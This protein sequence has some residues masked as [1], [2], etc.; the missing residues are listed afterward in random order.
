MG[1]IRV[2]AASG[3]A[4][5]WAQATVILGV[6]QLAWETDT[7]IMRVGDGM[8]LEPALPIAAQVGPSGPQIDDNIADVSASVVWSALNTQA[9]INAALV[10]ANAYTDQ[11]VKGATTG[12]QQPRIDVCYQNADGSW[13]SRPNSFC[14]FAFTT[15]G[16]TTP[17]TWLV[18]GIDELF[19][20]N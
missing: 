14:V 9:Q 10:L 17:P 1:D 16:S 4:A 2:V 12:N 20:R 13:P 3:T 5:E 7:Q 18:Q 11:V 8:S 15:N 19:Y 6:G